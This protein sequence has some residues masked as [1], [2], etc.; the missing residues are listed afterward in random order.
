MGGSVQFVLISFWVSVV[1]NLWHFARLPRL[2]KLFIKDAQFSV[3][4]GVA[5]G[6]YVLMFNHSDVREI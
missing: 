2:R 3:I 1:A 5:T 6:V 4:T